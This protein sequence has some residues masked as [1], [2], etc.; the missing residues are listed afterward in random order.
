M[1][2][3]PSARDAF[4]TTLDLFETGLSLMRQNLRRADSHATDD[5]IDCRLREWLR[6]RP[7]AEGGDSWERCAGS[8]RRFE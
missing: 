4:L 3:G 6:L 2:S 7:G 5:E 8:N 1:R